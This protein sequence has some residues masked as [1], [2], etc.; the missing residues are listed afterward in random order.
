MITDTN[1][2]IEMAWIVSGVW[3][4][5]TL[6]K[7]AKDVWKTWYDEKNYWKRAHGKLVANYDSLQ[8]K[9]LELQKDSPKGADFEARN[10]AIIEARNAG[11]KLRVIARNYG[12][13]ISQIHYII[14]KA[15]QQ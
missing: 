14:K 13:T 11:A 1:S 10:K 15:E 12:M 9:L 7:E 5:V 6:V 3:A 8:Q 4:S 2:L